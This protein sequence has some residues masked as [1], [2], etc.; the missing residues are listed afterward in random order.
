MDDITRLRYRTV[1]LETELRLV[2]EQLAQ[3]RSATQ[4]IINC[5]AN[6]HAQP[7]INGTNV[8]GMIDRSHSAYAAYSDTRTTPVENLITFDGQDHSPTVTEETDITSAS[9][10]IDGPIDGPI[11]SPIE[12]PVQDL[13]EWRPRYT[14]SPAVGRPF[15]DHEHN[16]LMGSAMFI[17]DMSEKEQIEHWGEFQQKNRTHTAK[18][19]KTY[20]DEVIRPAFLDRAGV[21]LILATPTQPA[22]SGAKPVPITPSVPELFYKYNSTDP[23][24]FRTVL[25][26]N[27]DTS[28]DETL[29]KMSEYKIKSATFLNTAGMKTRPMIKTNSTLVV[30]WDAEEAKAFVD[31]CDEN[32]VLILSPT[33]P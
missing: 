32:V 2:K 29:S 18:E 6:E 25:I 20:Y 30:F 27:I 19:W 5:L 31:S 17:E 16:R 8:Y 7:H 9:P 13:G 21:K 10:L 26:N 22:K 4:Y 24:L 15:E 14:R 1:E 11:Q 28:L 23:H 12:T 33:R 3:A